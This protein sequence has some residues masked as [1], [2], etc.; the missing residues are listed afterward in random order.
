MNSQTDFEHGFF[1]TFR[2]TLQQSLQFQ[3]NGLAHQYGLQPEY[4]RERLVR[5]HQDRLIR[6]TAFNV[7]R[8]YYQL[9]DRWDGHEPFFAANSNG[10]YFQAELRADGAQLA[11]NLQKQP[12]G[13]L[14]TK[15]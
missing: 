4:I 14:A 8:G 5:W 9:W 1:S 3:I 13:F 7:D 2:K 12:I 11:E 15:G 6:L 10:N